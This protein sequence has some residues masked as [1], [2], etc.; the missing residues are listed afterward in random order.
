MEECKKRRGTVLLSAAGIVVNWTILKRPKVELVELK[1]LFR[2]A[3]NMLGSGRKILNNTSSSYMQKA[4]EKWTYREN[5]NGVRRLEM[6]GM[7]SAPWMLLVDLFVPVVINWID[8]DDNGD[9]G[10]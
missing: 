7:L 10:I 4:Y 2:D 6:L 8:A 5:H 3:V 9:D 1:K